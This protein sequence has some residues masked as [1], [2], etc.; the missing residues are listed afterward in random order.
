MILCPQEFQSDI[1]TLIL[2]YLLDDCVVDSFD[3]DRKCVLTTLRNN[4]VWVELWRFSEYIDSIKDINEKNLVAL[5]E[6]FFCSSTTIFN[7]T[8][9]YLHGIAAETAH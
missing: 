8:L 7:V 9:F 2:Q 5:Q 4:I 6:I 1:R 3:D